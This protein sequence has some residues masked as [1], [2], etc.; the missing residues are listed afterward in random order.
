MMDAPFDRLLSF[1]ARPAAQ[2]KKDNRYYRDGGLGPL[3]A[4]LVNE[5]MIMI[6]LAWL[7]VGACHVGKKNKFAATRHGRSC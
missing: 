2:A 5:D 7:W 6:G 4:L 1:T 3:L